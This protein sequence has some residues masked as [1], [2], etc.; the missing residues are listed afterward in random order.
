MSTFEGPGVTSRDP[1]ERGMMGSL[2][3]AKSDRSGV[4]CLDAEEKAAVKT[5]E[6][7][8]SRGRGCWLEEEAGSK[9]ALC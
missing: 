2:A 3:M 6:D 9:Y 1:D 5:P 4:P 7:S 8:V